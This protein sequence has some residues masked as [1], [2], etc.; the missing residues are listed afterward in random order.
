MPRA[1]DACLTSTRLDCSCKPKAGVQFDHGIKK[2]DPKMAHYILA[3]R[4]CTCIVYLAR[5]PRFLSEP[6]D[7]VFDATSE[8]KN[9]EVLSSH[10]TDSLHDYQAVLI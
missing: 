3:K 10:Y 8:E 5:T 7:L 1:L 9:L 4:K 2:W 6:C